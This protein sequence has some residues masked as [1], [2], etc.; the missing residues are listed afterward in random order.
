[1]K[2]SGFSLACIR[3]VIPS[4]ICLSGTASAQL[5]WDTN[6]ATA[7]SDTTVTSAIWGVTDSWTT[8]STGSSATTAYTTNSNVI[9][10]AGTNATGAYYL[11]INGNQT[12]NGITVEEGTVTFSSM[13][14][15]GNVTPGLGTL[16]LGAG[17]ITLANGLH[18][19][20]LFGASLGNLTLN[21]SQSWT[22]NTLTDAGAGTTARNLTVHSGIVG[23]ATTGNT[24]TL[25]L[26]SAST[27]TIGATNLTGVIANGAGGGTLALTKTGGNLLTISGTASNT[28][29]GLTTVSGGTLTLAKS[30][31]FDA[32]AGNVT[33]TSGT[34]SLGNANQIANTSALTVTG[35]TANFGGRDET[36]ASITLSGGGSFAT[37]NTGGTSTPST[38]T[39]TGAVSTTGTSKIT[40]NSGGTLTVDSLTLSGTNSAI[41]NANSGNI[42]IG[43]NHTN[44]VTTLNIGAGGLTMSGQ[45]IQVNASAG[46]NKGSRINLNGDL[47]ATGTANNVISIFGAPEGAGNL[48]ELNL[49]TG[50]RTFAIAGGTTTVGLNIAGQNLTKTGA[51]ILSLTG[52][53]A[54]TGQTLVSRG[55]LAIG[56]NNALGTTAGDTVVAAGASLRLSNN[57]TVTGETLTINATSTTTS[58][59]DNEQIYGLR[60]LSGNNEWAG[61]VN[62]ALTSQNARFYSDDGNL[63]VSGPV[64]LS[65][66]QAGTTEGTALVL[67]G[68][69]SGHGEISGNI[70]QDLASTRLLGIIKNTA[71]TWTLSGTNTYKGQTLVYNGIL[72][73]SSIANNLGTA[74]NAIGLGDQAT[75][76]TL[77]YTGSGADEATARNFYL[78]SDAAG[79]GVIDHSGTNVF[80]ING[81]VSSNGATNVGK[82]ITLQ[83]SGTGVLNGNISNGTG[84]G[85]SVT[86]FVKTG[87]GTWTLSNTAKAYSGTTS[88][89]GG[90]L[91]VSTSLTNTTAVSVTNGTL[92]LQTAEVINNASTLT[93]GSN[94][95][96]IAAVG[97]ETINGATTISGNA[98]LDLSLGNSILRLGNSSSADWT[99]GLLTILGWNGNTAGGGLEQ[100]SFGTDAT[101]LTSTQLGQVQFS[102]VD[103]LYSARIL[104]SGE[105]VP[106]AL[107][108]EA[109]SA[110]LALVGGAGLLVRRRRK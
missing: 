87:S 60:N 46:T 40:L 74:T 92:A 97:T 69:T 31:G 70:S 30:A 103:G 73:V 1:M 13:D 56:S 28:Y 43:G 54:H 75:T 7:G 104:A 93:L 32:I 14:A 95:T 71:D 36:I 17:G 18:G 16:A 65:S 109:S 48:I 64:V 62:V 58:S 96:L 98:I 38:V 80:T 2:P 25:T 27:G 94:S 47:T 19:E 4:L 68:G 67:G 20:A 34:L 24:Q 10:S 23:T 77:R 21:A 81:N 59:P 61:T 12:A 37:G 53:N 79:G 89:T 101:G 44:Q 5:Y 45:S 110:A 63:K 55:I 29:T 102:L 57:I 86:S 52:N 9:V 8:D 100:V 82:S 22:N 106:D 26:A 78:R 76:G 35:G 51:G 33:V 15:A 99:G 50:T 105:I 11:K 90:R 91:N 85:T 88:V 49:G 39:V 84:T 6:G 66:N 72:S 107:I 3:A 42:L 83:G 108:P 41:A